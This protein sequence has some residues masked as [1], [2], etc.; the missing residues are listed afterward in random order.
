MSLG[1]PSDAP[2]PNPEPAVGLAALLQSRGAPLVEA[3]DEHLPGAREH[4]EGTAAYAFATSVEL[5][6]GRAQCEV[7]REV[8]KLHE[9]GQIYVP[10]AVLTRPATERDAD[11]HRAFEAHYESGYRLARGAGIP[12]HACGW[13]LRAR[14]SYDG[15]GPERLRGDTIPIEARLIRAACTCQTVL[16]E[17]AEEDAVPAHRRAAD[18]L[19]ALAGSELDPRV[20]G[21]LVAVIERTSSTG[22]RAGE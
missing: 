8:A 19:S 14:E 22:R 20:A 9:V 1:H 16:A 5:G 21:A 3:L 10:A 13:L 6:F 2:S 7:A 4:A 11:E 12:E 15:S 17:P 18:R